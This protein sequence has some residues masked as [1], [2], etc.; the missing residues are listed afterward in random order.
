MCCLAEFLMSV[1]SNIIGCFL[2]TDDV[3]VELLGQLGT[4]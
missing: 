4:P 3:A 1:T 2:S